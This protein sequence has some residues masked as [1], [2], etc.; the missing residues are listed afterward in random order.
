VDAVTDRVLEE[1]DTRRQEAEQEVQ[2]RVDAVRDDAQRRIDSLK[3]IATDRARLAQDSIRRAAEAEAAR[4][5]ALAAQELRNRLKLD[6][7]RADSI[8]NSIPGVDRVKEE[9]ERFN[10]F[11]K[12]KKPGG[13]K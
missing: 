8:L 10:P 9:L 5:K 1:V 7:L 3:S 11:K 13:G 6:S 2:N 4:L 12:K